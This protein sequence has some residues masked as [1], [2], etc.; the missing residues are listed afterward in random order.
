MTRIQQLLTQPIKLNLPAMVKD[1]L[2]IGCDRLPSLVMIWAF[3]EMLI[4]LFSNFATDR[5][6]DIR[7]ITCIQRAGPFFY[8]TSR[9]KDSNDS[10]QEADAQAQSR[11]DIDF[12]PGKSIYDMSWV[13]RDHD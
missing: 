12:G 7:F 6:G 9:A 5:G 13:S 4:L 1:K 2:Q 8:V 10:Q 11:Y 3:L